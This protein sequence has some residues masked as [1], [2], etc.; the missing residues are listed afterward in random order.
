[1]AGRTVTFVTSNAKKLEE[2]QAILQGTVN[3]QSRKVECASAHST[4]PRPRPAFP[5]PFPNPSAT[6]RGHSRG[7][8]AWSRRVCPAVSAVLEV[9]GTPQSIATY[10]VQQAVA[11]VQGPVLVEDTCLCFNALHGLPGPY[12]YV[13]LHASPPTP[14]IRTAN[15]IA[16]TTAPPRARQQMVLGIPRPRWFV[17]IFSR[18]YSH[19]DPKSSYQVSR[20]V[21]RCPHAQASTS[22][23][24]AMRT[25]ARTPCACSPTAQARAMRRS[26]SRAAR[27]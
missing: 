11:A 25:R 23:W 21:V 10:K 5:N 26:C 27:W 16:N 6:L 1:M 9:Q 4:L 8:I 7:H 2:L 12:M 3:V 15:T 18:A 13:H 14:P 24:L 19:A 17:R 20:S 22:C